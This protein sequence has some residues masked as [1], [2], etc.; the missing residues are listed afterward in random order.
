MVSTNTK[1]TEFVTRMKEIAAANLE[2]II[3]YGSAARGNFRPDHSD[4]NLLCVL[5][6]LTTEELGRVAPVVKWW[7]TEQREP[8]P[9]FFTAEELHMAADVFSIEFLDIKA[10]RRV[11]FGADIAANIV[12]PMNLHRVQVERDLRTTVLK[13]RGQ[14][15]RA[16]GNKDELAPVL[17]KSFSGVLVL[18][19]HTL[20]VFGE[21]PPV[22]ARGVIARAAALT[23][24]HAA[25]F[26]AA[27]ELHESGELRGEIILIYGAYLKALE[28]VIRAL[29]QHMP[30]REWRRVEAAN[31]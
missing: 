13:L 26:D 2:S 16:P 20:I 29:D 24:S 6:A 15:L 31:S 22:E 27:M 19:R 25:A 11:L 17:R 4:L 7:R 14:Y 1:L 21:E 9:L 18:L 8:V 3:L 10:S 23:R 5:G 12:V 28:Q 30:K